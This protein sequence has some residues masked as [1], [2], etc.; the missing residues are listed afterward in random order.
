METIKNI[1]MYVGIVAILIPFVCMCL[2]TIKDT[3]DYWRDN[4]ND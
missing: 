3:I 4:N 1:L 2:I